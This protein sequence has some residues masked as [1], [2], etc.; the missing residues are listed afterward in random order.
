MASA[1]DLLHPG[2]ALSTDPAGV[3]IPPESPEVAARALYLAAQ[4]LAGATTFFFAAYLFAYFY[5]R[6]IDANHAWRPATLQPNHLL[7]GLIIACVIASATL[8]L[9]A[10]RRMR[11]GGGGWLGLAVGALVLGLVMVALQVI[12]WTVQGFGPTDGAYASV[13]VAW[14]SLYCVAV[15]GAMYWLEVQVATESRARRAPAHR[16]KGDIADPDRLISPG[17]DA[18]AFYWAYLAAVGVVSFIILYLLQ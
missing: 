1:D 18:A 16:A 10:A 6:S 4:L 13:F 15:L 12:E 5:L 8:A 9:L 17:L 11:G 7:G 2:P 3:E 14:T